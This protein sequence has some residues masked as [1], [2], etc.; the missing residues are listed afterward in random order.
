M[1]IAEIET[2]GIE[3]TT[4]TTEIETAGIETTT[5]MRIMPGMRVITTV[6]AIMET[7]QTSA[8]T[9][10]GVIAETTETRKRI[11]A[12]GT[13]IREPAHGTEVTRIQD[14]PLIQTT[15]ATVM[16]PTR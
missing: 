5:E 7:I 3:T 12:Q 13:A 14:G 15:I 6:E 2:A 4:R 9:M 10:A 1:K 11:I 16:G 8:G